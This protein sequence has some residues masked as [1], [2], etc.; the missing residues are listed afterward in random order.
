M[1]ATRI[2]R[3]QKGGFYGDMRTHHRET[4]PATFD[5]P[6]CWLPR[7]VDNSAGGQVWVPQGVWGGLGGKALHLSW[8]RCRVFHLLHEEVEGDWQ[9]GVVPLDCEA[10]A[11]GSITGAFSPFDGHLYVVGL[12]GWQTAGKADG[13]LQ[14][15]RYTGE[16]LNLPVEL[17]ARKEGLEITF[18]DALDPIAATNPENYVLERWNYRWSEA[19]GSDHWSVANPD[20]QRHDAVRVLSVTIDKDRKTVFLKIE[21]MQPV[22]QMKLTYALKSAEGET[23]T[24]TIHHTVNRLGPR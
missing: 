1:P 22:M 3:Y 8:G 6:L 15:V 4:P 19:Y 5:P 24:N 21:D 2:D 14:R 12:H 7:D 23:F 16:D 17:H 11:S 10:F 9:G 18:S 13:C 20:E